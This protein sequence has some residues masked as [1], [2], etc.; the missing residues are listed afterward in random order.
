MKQFILHFDEIC[1]K[2]GNRPYFEAIL[3]SNIK[4]AMNHL[5]D[6]RVHFLR[7]RVMVDFLGDESLENLLKQFSRIPGICDF[8]P[9]TYS[10]TK[11][12]SI[13][14]QAIEQT[15]GLQGSF[16]V[17]VKRSDKS[18]PLTSQEISSRVG[19]AIYKAHSLKVDLH[20][21]DHILYINVHKDETY[22]FAKKYPGMGGL[23][24]GSSGRVL[25]FISG[26]IDSPVAA[27]C[28]LARGCR[29][30]YVHF[31]NF[32]DDQNSVRDKVL[33]LVRT[34]AKYQPYTRI[35]MVPFGDPQRAI[36]GA[37]PSRLRMV[38]YRRVMLNI[39]SALAQIDRCKAFITGDSVGQVAS[40][41]LDN[42]RTIQAAADL[43][44]LSPLIGLNKRE[45][46]DR[47]NRIGTYETSI[48][49]YEDCCSFLIDPHPDTAV[50]LDELSKF[51]A[52]LPMHDL[53]SGCIANTTVYGFQ[54]G[55]ATHE[56]SGHLKLPQ[57]YSPSQ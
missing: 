50:N 56:R 39:G 4:E 7:G 43:P 42:L 36:I 37:V 28:M 10:E 27:H 22:L 48:L 45:I 17:T 40:Q 29:I 33:T 3:R 20:N 6:N 35:Y 12:E 51:E 23:P 9:V 1:L 8:S 5:G 53:L 18:F 21:P 41:T 47:A 52:E 57:S 55:N 13:Y 15:E 31:H 11:M 24:V 25:A 54:F 30:S 34:L 49:P 14:A 46:I 2:G 44:I 38:A 19:A 16:R 26:G 32:Q